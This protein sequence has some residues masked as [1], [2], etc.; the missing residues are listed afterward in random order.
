M[1]L[2][3]LSMGDRARAKT[4]HPYPQGSENEIQ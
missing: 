4:D 1:T 3:V 2:I